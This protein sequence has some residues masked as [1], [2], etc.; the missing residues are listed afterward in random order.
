MDE[1]TW[2]KTS[3]N[4]FYFS[5]ILQSQRIIYKMIHDYTKTLN[6]APNK[7]SFNQNTPVSSLYI[8]LIYGT[9]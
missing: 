6:F 2:C 5:T 1:F 4:D 3:I 9:K 8:H 7:A